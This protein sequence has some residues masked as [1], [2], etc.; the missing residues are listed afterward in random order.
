MNALKASEYTV[1]PS[2]DST[3]GFPLWARM[4]CFDKYYLRCL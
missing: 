3:I 2:P 4:I 1:F